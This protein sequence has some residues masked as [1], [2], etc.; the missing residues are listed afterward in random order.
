MTT[1]GLNPL[2]REYSCMIQAMICAF[3]LTSGAGMSLRGPITSWISETNL[4]V[5]RSSSPALRSRGL[6]SIPPL[7]PP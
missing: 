3:V 7:A 4:R 2:M 1:A 5:T 6:Q